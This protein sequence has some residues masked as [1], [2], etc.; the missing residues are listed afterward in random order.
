MMSNEVVTVLISGFSSCCCWN[1]GTLN[2]ELTSEP[3]LMIAMVASGGAIDTV[4]GSSLAKFAWPNALAAAIC[5]AIAWIGHLHGRHRDAVLVGKVGDGFDRRIAGV[6]QERL[7]AQRRDAAHLLRRA[8]R[9]CPQHE[10]ARRAAGSDVDIAGDERVVH[11][12]GAVERDPGYLDRGNAER[13]CVLLDELLMLHHVELQIAH[14]ILAREP[15]FRRL[16]ASRR[17]RPGDDQGG[18]RSRN[19]R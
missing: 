1:G 18:E 7:R 10:Q 3:P 17:Q 2:T 15:D 8:L 16:R 9:L 14:G 6:E 12:R 5:S 4:S 11:R 13:A 19:A